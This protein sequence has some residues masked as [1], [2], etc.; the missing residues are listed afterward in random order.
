[1]AGSAELDYDN[2]YRATV[3]AP[4]DHVPFD[5]SD[6]IAELSAYVGPRAGYYLRK[7][8]RRLEDPQGDVGINWV[9]FFFPGIWLAYR[10]M[11]MAVFTYFTVVFL[12]GIAKELVF[13][14]V[15]HQPGS[16]LVVNLVFN[17]LAGL[18]CALYGNGWYLAQARRTIAGLRAEGYEGQDLLYALSC[19]GGTSIAAIFI[20]NLA[21][22]FV[23]AL[24]FMFLMAIGIAI[25]GI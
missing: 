10:K 2:P 7:W 6:E 4:A 11:Y 25:S 9:A 8:I 15:L 1:M 16:P 5:S 24:A 17:I 21:A 14:L 18:V 13:I 22:G 12:V 20:V 19:R 3:A 23:L